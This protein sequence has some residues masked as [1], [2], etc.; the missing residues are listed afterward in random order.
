LRE[1]VTQALT[2]EGETGHDSARRTALIPFDNMAVITN[3]ALVP[4]GSSGE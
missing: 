1:L 3:G 4:C 2:N